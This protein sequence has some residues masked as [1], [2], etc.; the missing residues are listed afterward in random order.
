M[1]MPETHER[2]EV[3]T[4]VLWKDEDE[5]SGIPCG[6]AWIATLNGEIIE[7]LGW[8]IKPNAIK[9]AETTGRDFEEV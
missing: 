1:P 8:V 7:E 3:T 6:P 5:V 4:K 9:L 2:P